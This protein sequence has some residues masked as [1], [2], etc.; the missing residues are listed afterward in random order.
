MDNK[1]IYLDKKG[2]SITVWVIIAIAL[3]G[4]MALFFTI[5]VRPTITGGQ[6]KDFNPGRFIDNCAENAVQESVDLM[7]PHGG[8][9]ED[10]NSIS[11]NNINVSYLCRNKGNYEPCISQRPVYINDL[12][13]EIIRNSEEKIE[14]CFENLRKEVEKRNGKVDLGEMTLVVNFAIDRIFLMI[15]RLIVIE[16]QGQTERFEEYKV[17]I[18]N[19]LYNLARIAMDV[20]NQEAKYCYFEYVG[21]NALHPETDIRKTTLDDGTRI[22][23]IKERNSD[24]DLNIAIRGCVVPAGI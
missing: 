17:E 20:S 11:Y 16:K 1:M 22:Y 3:V 19:P 21:Y 10:K 6:D 24:K 2:Q 15:D 23:S 4:A 8:F 12:K 14:N 7:L 5:E 13:K 9:I 18:V